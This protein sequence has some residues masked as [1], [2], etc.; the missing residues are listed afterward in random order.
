[1]EL[2]LVSSMSK[3]FLDEAPREDLP[4]EP[5]TCL[6]NGAVSFQAAWRD[7]GGEVRSLTKLELRSR[8][9]PWLTVRRVVHVPVKF[10]A[11]PDADDNYLRR[12]PGLYP[13][14]LSP[15]PGMWR[16]WRDMWE[17]AWIEL[18]A[19]G[20]PAGVWPVEVAICSADGRELTARTVYI[21]VLRAEMPPQ[22]LIHT[23][24]FHCDGLCRLYGVDMFSD[25]FFAIAERFLRA[26]ARRGINMVLTPIHTP[27]LDT[28]EGGERMTCQLVDI[29]KTAGGWQFDFQKLDRWVEMAQRA[30]MKYFEMAHLFTQW[31]AKHAPKIVAKVGGE[32]R[33]VFGWETEAAGPEYRSFLRAYLTALTGHLRALGIADRC[34]FHISDEPSAE[35]MDS[36]RA[37]REAVGELLDGFPI[38]DALSDFSFYRTGLVPRPVPATNHIAPFLEAKVPGLW[39]YYCVGQY[40]DVSNRFIAMPGTRTR[41]LGAQL[42]ANGIEG[43]LQ[44]GYNFYNTQ[45]SLDGVDPFVSTDADGFTPAG[46]AFQ[47]YP[48]RDQTPEESMRMVMLGDA[49]QD[50]RVFQGLEA[51]KG[52]G[53]VLKMIEEE[54]G[55]PAS[56]DRCPREPDALLRLRIRAERELAEIPG[57]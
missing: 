14:R 19:D 47:V 36:Y 30:G 6:Q 35:M 54:L 57:C 2:R 31:G 10:A 1:M 40:R 52:R 56:F 16:T 45:H 33:R 21:E 37:A 28:A 43:F 20:A 26:A 4:R 50:V 48:A 55:G 51:R 12:S 25:A 42:Y 7:A 22:T 49:M 3:V 44:W 18:T 34:W 9:L 5:L 41:V 32:V 53:Y 38:M 24:W 13:D 23:Q 11:F 39:T 15:A 17:S 29:E 27:P 46:D 8:L